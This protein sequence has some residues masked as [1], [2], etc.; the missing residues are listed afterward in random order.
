MS[1]QS[2]ATPE[3]PALTLADLVKIAMPIGARLTQQGERIAVAEST[4]GGLLAAALLAVPGAS[5][6]FAG[7]V[8]IYTQISR[9]EL[10]GVHQ[11][12]V[13]GLKPLTIG[14]AAAFADAVRH[15]LQAQ[16]GIGEL[17]LAGPG[18][19]R[20]GKPAGTTVVAITGATSAGSEWVSGHDDRERN[21]WAFATH[22]L[23]TLA[24]ALHDP[25]ERA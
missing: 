15:R 24:A 21:M 5:A 16:W 8:V 22:A 2:T 4:T 18:P 10:L 25:V 14:M 20:Y 17:G 9:R 6:Y 19:G 13:A 12:D 23:L 3:N 11:T 7:G 1:L